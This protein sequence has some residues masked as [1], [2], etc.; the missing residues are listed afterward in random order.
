MVCSALI[1]GWMARDSAR[2]VTIYDGR[3][4]I[5][6]NSVSQGRIHTVHNGSQIEGRV[7]AKLNRL[8]GLKL[9]KLS[10]IVA[11]GGNDGLAFL[12]RYAGD[13]PYEELHGLKA[14]ITNEKDIS[15]DLGL[16]IW[17]YDQKKQTFIKCYG[18]S[19]VPTSQGPYRI[20]L[21]L[22]SAQEPIAEWRVGELY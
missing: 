22:K 14:L 19:P 18:L 17:R 16:G 8:F 5:L 13:F 7:R 4:K 1:I 10:P 20:I 6:F 9:A 15:R 12:M 11:G 3:F 2:D 21:T